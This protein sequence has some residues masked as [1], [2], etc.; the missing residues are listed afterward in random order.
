MGGIN[1]GSLAVWVLNPDWLSRKC[2]FVSRLGEV[3]ATGGEEC[4]P[5]P[6]FASYTLAF[7]LHLRKIMEKLRQ[8]NRKALG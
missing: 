3:A 7:A 4:K 8:G 2:D 1:F 6:D 5:Y